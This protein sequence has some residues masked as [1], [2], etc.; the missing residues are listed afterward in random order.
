MQ[1]LAK[2]NGDSNLGETANKGISLTHCKTEATKMTDL[3]GSHLL[4]TLLG[5]PRKN[6]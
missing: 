1:A 3:R 6:M 5:P 2:Q 4:T